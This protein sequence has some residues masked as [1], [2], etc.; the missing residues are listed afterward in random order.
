MPEND[1]SGGIII[2]MA[3]E[4]RGDIKNKKIYF[5]MM[6]IIAC[7]L[8]I[9]NHL[10]AYGLY[11]VPNGGRQFL[12]MCL[13]MTTQINVP[14]FFMISGALLFSRKEEWSL[15]FK[16]RF[17]RIVY[18]LLFIDL[19]LMPIFKIESAM[20]G[21]VYEFSFSNFLHAF[22]QN[23][24]DGAYWYL[25]SYLGVLFVLPLLQ[26][27]AKEIT[28]TEILGLLGLHF[29]MYSF[30]PILNLFLAKKQLPSISIC[31]DFNVPFAYDRAFFFTIIGYYLEYH[32]D[33]TKVKMKHL[34]GL[35]TAALA[36]ILLSDWCT[37]QDAALNGQYLDKYVH[38]FDYIIAI[39]VFILIKYLFVVGFPRL[40]EGKFYKIVC[41]C[42]SL[43]L[44]IYVLDPCLK[45][46]W[47][48]KYETWAEPHFPTLIVALGWI[49]FSTVLGGG[50]TCFLKKV[51]IISRI[52]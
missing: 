36:G 25:Y 41:F 23:R 12:Y 38:L 9:Y 10:S 7:V 15:V 22:T 13:T 24:M 48:V 49:V 34:Y 2:I 40:N 19:I 17:M 52:L 6:R 29:V 1:C 31:E 14:L 4:M 42:G 50:I 3:E 39:V 43:T 27:M 20:H 8:V 5:E 47:Y 11:S 32:V 44:G 30:L 18:L 28:K 45:K 37:Y 21:T 33:V 26:R 16:N 51:P 35:I 46:M